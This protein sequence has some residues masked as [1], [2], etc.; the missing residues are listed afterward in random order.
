[1]CII[2]DQLMRN[3]IKRALRTMKDFHNF[4]IA[5]QT[6]VLEETKREAETVVGDKDPPKSQFCLENIRKFSYKSE[7]DKF[8]QSNPLLLAAI[9]GSI[10]KQKVTKYSDISRKGFGGSNTSVDIDL[11]PSVVQTVSRILKN[12]HPRSFSTVPCINSLYLWANRAPGHIV[13]FYN[14]LGDSFRLVSR[15]QI[16]L[17]SSFILFLS[18]S[19][20]SLSLSLFLY[21]FLSFQLLLFYQKRSY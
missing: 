5:L 21:F 9:I 18:L 4:D 19:P 15:I 16:I 1:M 17:Y 2:R 12:R 6:F 20:L 7:L 10:S 11:V 3:R 8:Q 14:S 13:H